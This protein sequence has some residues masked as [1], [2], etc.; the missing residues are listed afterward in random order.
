MSYIDIQYAAQTSST[1]NED[2]LRAW[3]EAAL[4]DGNENAE[5][6][7]R[8]VNKQEI[9]AL[10]AQFR[11][12]DAATNVLSF[13]SELPAELKLNL[14]GDVIICADVVEQEASEQNKTI[15]AH[16][17]HMVVHGALHLQGY[18]HVDDNDAARMEALETTL[19]TALGFPAPY[20]S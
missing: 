3:C 5:L 20:H 11:Q 16:W 12:K 1:P 8:V 10:N 14:L 13:P 15:E 2:S 19:I 4:Q 6:T 9:R 7:L 17:A 18:D